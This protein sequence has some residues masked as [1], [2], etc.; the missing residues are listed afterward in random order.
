MSFELNCSFKRLF[1]LPDKVELNEYPISRLRKSTLD[2]ICG[3][4]RKMNVRVP[5]GFDVNLFDKDILEMKRKNEDFSKAI[6]PDN[7]VYIQ[8]FHHFYSTPQSFKAF[9]PIPELQALINSYTTQFGRNAVGIH[10]RR[11]DNK[12]SI[13]HSPVEIFI[14]KMKEEISNNPDTRFYLATDSVA[15]EILIKNLFKERLMVHEKSLSRNTEKGVQDALVDLY[16]LSAT[17]KIIGSYFSSFSEVAAQINS[18]N[19]D[20]IYK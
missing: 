20:L 16:C 8:T 11:Q 14:E 9:T 13:K 5:F 6:N 18:I 7:K 17:R 15:D 19:L 1:I 12:Q 10:L 2:Y 4:L 3:N